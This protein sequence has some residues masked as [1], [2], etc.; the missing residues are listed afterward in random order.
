MKYSV[1][2]TKQALGELQTTLHWA[3]SIVNPAPAI[4]ALP[5]N[6][7]IRCQST[8]LPQA[9]E[10][11]NKVELQGHVINYVG[12]T[13]KNGEIPMVFVEGTD[14]L[15]IGYFTK[16]QQARWSGDGKDT[17]GVQRLTKDLKADIK[18]ELM[19]PD[20]VV[21]QTY[22]LIG[23]MPRLENGAQL[24]QTADPMTPNITF[25]YDDWHI[26]ANGV[27]W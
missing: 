15:A 23:A 16:W 13:T 8:T 14:A 25:E 1:N 18:I 26:T 19:G 6:L 27:S 3:M 12:K 21:T 4:G 5:E 11:T 24:G 20:D 17:T 2:R 9:Q 22:M 10:E 7:Q